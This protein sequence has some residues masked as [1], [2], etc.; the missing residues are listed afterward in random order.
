MFEK[1]PNPPVGSAFVNDIKVTAHTIGSLTASTTVKSDGI[2]RQT[3]AV[4]KRT[5][6]IHL[7]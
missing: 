4:Q 5:N 3:E 7:E 2:G 6:L 1:A